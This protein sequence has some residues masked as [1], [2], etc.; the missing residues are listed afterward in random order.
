M[1]QDLLSKAIQLTN[2]QCL[3]FDPTGDG[4]FSLV[5]H[6]QDSHAPLKW[7]NTVQGA[8]GLAYGIPH[9]SDLVV[10]VNIVFI[11]PSYR[12]HF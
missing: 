1:K 2:L 9:D 4:F 7:C 3:V 8:D 12:P 11:H 10:R 5:G 6:E